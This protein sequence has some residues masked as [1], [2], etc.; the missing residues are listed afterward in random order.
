MTTLATST[1]GEF[2]LTLRGQ[3]EDRILTTLRRWPYW[4]RADVERDP[5]NPKRCL[6]VTLVADKLHEPMVRDILKRSFGMIFPVE[7]GS[8]E[9]TPEEPQLSKR[10]RWR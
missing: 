7:G 9:L 3:D 5:S 8:A 10:G 2:T 1:S 4:L 6:S